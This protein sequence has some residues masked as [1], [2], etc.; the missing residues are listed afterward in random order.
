MI[1]GKQKLLNRQKGIFWDVDPLQLN[2][3]AI[4]ERVLNYGNIDSVKALFKLYGLRHVKNVFCRQIK[5]KRNNY[6]PQT[7]NYFNLYFQRHV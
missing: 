4:I 6:H 3:E 5:R 7:I 2:D 1:N